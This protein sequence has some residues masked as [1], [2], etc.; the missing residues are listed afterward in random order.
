MNNSPTF[1]ERI[2]GSVRLSKVRRYFTPTAYMLRRIGFFGALLF[3]LLLIQCSLAEFSIF[4]G[5]VPAIVAAAVSALGFFDSER[6]G[7]VAGIAAGWALDAFGAP[8]PL[9]LLPLA[10]LAVGYFSGRTAGRRLPRAILPWGI[11]LGGTAA[12]NMLITLIYCIAGPMQLG[13]VGLV[14]YTLLPELLWTLVLGIPAGLLSLLV[15][16]IVKRG[17]TKRKRQ[18]EE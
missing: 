1:I 7:A 5:S 13:F 3:F 15:V 16:R 11:C 18:S 17:D 2:L 12:V 9:S 4:R 6:T 10:L 14:F 8:A